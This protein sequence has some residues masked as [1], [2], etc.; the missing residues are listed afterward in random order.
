MI[1][2][3]GLVSTEVG[4]SAV[5]QNEV[6][7]PVLDEA[8]DIDHCLVCP[9]LRDVGNGWSSVTCEVRPLASTASYVTGF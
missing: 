7:C 6:M 4:R 3:R 5:S 2:T 1:G 8:V 9:R